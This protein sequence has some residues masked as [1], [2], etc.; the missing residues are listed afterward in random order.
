MGVYSIQKIDEL[1]GGDADFALSIIQVFLEETPQDMYS[2]EQAIAAENHTLIYQAAHK[3]KPNV[4]L[5]G[6]VRTHQ[7]ILGIEQQGRSNG[8]LQQIRS[9]FAESELLAK[10]MEQIKVDYKLD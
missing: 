4:D 3:I 10:A 2:L 5:L 6:M 9:D 8:D 1:S 7:L